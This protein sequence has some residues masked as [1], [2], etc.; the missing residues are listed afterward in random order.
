[1]FYSI[2][3]AIYQPLQ[4]KK[5][6]YST[7]QEDSGAF[8][9]VDIPE[10]QRLKERQVNTEEVLGWSCRPIDKERWVNQRKVPRGT[11]LHLKLYIQGSREDYSNPRPISKAH[12]I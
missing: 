2:H 12:W 6:D 9:E 10:E 3:T 4:V 8:G 7:S 5:L 1:L 11:D